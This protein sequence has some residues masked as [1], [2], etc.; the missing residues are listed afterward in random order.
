MSS[1][2]PPARFLP[3]LTEVVKPTALSAVQP[4][5]DDLIARVMERL[6]PILN[7]RLEDYF[8]N[9]LRVQ[10]QQMRSVLQQDLAE[11]V[12]TALEVELAAPSQPGAPR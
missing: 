8:E 3:T 6:L 12:R 7:A 4:I 11:A 9:A 5:D 1:E 2:K 10:L